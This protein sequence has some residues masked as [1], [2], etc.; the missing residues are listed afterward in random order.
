[1]GLCLASGWW[2]QLR[3]GRLAGLFIEGGFSSWW[4]TAGWGGRAEEELRTAGEKAAARLGWKPRREVLGSRW[5]LSHPE[6]QGAVRSSVEIHLSM[7]LLPRN[8][9]GPLLVE[10]LFWN[11]APL[12]P[13]DSSY[14]HSHPHTLP[15]C[16][17]RVDSSQSDTCQ[18]WTEAGL[19]GTQRSWN[20]SE[21]SLWVMAYS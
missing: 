16:P 12:C 7:C 9:A 6:H 21:V 14:H 8:P 2:Q 13:Q 20:L 4:V 18:F 10:L 15:A 5:R 11:N 1:M 3:R 19:L 17:P